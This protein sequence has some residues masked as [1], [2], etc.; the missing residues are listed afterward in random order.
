MKKIKRF[1]KKYFILDN[2]NKITVFILFMILVVPPFLLYWL[3]LL[4]LVG[5]E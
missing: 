2:L 5:I 3:F 4:G 1:C